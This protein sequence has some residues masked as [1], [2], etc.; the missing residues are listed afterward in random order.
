MGQDMCNELHCYSKG[1]CDT[2]CMQ[3]ADVKAVV[4][5]WKTASGHAIDLI[6]EDYRCVCVCVCV[7]VDMREC[8]HSCV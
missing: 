1:K 2:A 6:V 3:A 4:Q 8:V 7:C 5:A